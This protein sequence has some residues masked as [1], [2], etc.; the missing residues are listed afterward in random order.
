M[1]HSQGTH[2]AR[3]IWLSLRLPPM[4]PSSSPCFLAGMISTSMDKPRPMEE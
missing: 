2:I 1:Q 3:R 4:T